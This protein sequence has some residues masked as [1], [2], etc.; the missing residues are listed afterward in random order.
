[1]IKASALGGFAVAVSVALALLRNKLTAVILGP[2]GVG[3]FAQVNLFLNLANTFVAL[4]LGVGLAKVVAES[5]ARG[6]LSALRG[7]IGAACLLTGALA[8]VVVVVSFVFAPLVARYAL[9]DDSHAP[10]F[11][12]AA[13]A[14][15]ASVM[16]MLFSSV[17]Q[18]LKE[19][20]RQSST[21]VWSAVVST[22][23][24]A[25]LLLMFGNVMS[26]VAASVVAAWISVALV[27]VNSRLAMR[28][29]QMV[30][31]NSWWHWAR[32]L[33]A[34][35]RLKHLRPLLVIGVS[36]VCVGTL[37]ALTDLFMRSEIV[38]KFGE[39]TNGFFQAG[40]AFS[41]QYMGVALGA[42]SLYSFPRFSEIALDTDAV[43]RELNQ[44]LRFIVL[45]VT[46][47]ICL[48]M[49]GNRWLVPLLFSA[50]FTETQQLLPL[51]LFRDFA[52]AIASALW[53]CLLPLNR[54]RFWLIA[55]VL[56]QVV[57]IVLFIAL[58]G[59][60]GVE[61]AI[62]NGVI[63]WT[64]ASVALLVYLRRAVNFSAA[65]ANLALIAISAG[66]IVAVY[67]LSLGGPIWIGGGG[68][69][70][71]VWALLAVKKREWRAAWDLARRKLGRVKESDTTK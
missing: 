33:F 5:R 68:A 19:I 47:C 53:I 10:L 1:L 58:F 70:M 20:G 27:M 43:R 8:L 64:L 23:L 17:L 65:P 29:A 63:G 25:A 45:F 21:R 32:E 50:K 31:S 9:N 16:A 13:L 18:G 3:T 35:A 11:A 39:Q 4:G 61:A 55:S 41:A 15:P 49:M 7:S 28:S 57:F 30:A 56:V 54:V 2:E 71:G 22:T 44:T 38:R 46:P 52:Q 42:L 37:V 12:V 60:L 48:L 59:R 66:L 24:M 69:L 26:W 62:W 40:N 6:D 67:F 36:S 34:E 51:F 14:I